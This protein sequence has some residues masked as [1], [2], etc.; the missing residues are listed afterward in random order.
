M[1]VERF[2][3]DTSFS[4][5]NH[6]ALESGEFHHLSHVVRCRVGEKIELVNG[7]NALAEATIVAIEKKKA[8]LKIDTVMTRPPGRHIILAQAIPRF[9]RLEFILEKG[10][11]LGASAF[12]LFPGAE[13]EKSD[14][15][16]NQ[17]ERMGLLTISAMKQCGRLDL[18][19]ILLKPPLTEW[20]STETAIFYG[21]T[22]PEAPSVTL[23]SKA[24]LILLVGPE[25]GLSSR[26][27]HHLDTILKAQG[28]HLNPN[29]LRTDTA[30]IAFLAIA[31]AE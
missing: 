23:F 9:N 2:F 29:I 31:N 7:R 15:S 10:T 1:P 18:P 4:E 30:A 24:P 13:S 16:P 11:E 3:S 19:P 12:W 27:I 6:C 8:I 21:D 26:E 5:G 28:V 22:R 20:Q 17:K 25:R 14:F